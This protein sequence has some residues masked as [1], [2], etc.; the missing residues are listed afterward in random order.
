MT[1]IL[2][3]VTFDLAA[4]ALDLS[5][6]RHQVIAA[7]IANRA[8]AGYEPR[9]LDFEAQLAAITRE[10]D[11]GAAPESLA[12]DLRTLASR[13]PPTIESGATV[14]LDD[15]INR[16]VA[17]TVQYQAVLAGLGKL[18]S[19]NRIAIEGGSA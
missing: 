19:L 16:L 3:N 17:N 12:Q 2:N 18:G 1:G 13:V 9:R 15:E 14:Q 8:T 6:A 10:I 4:A 5:M 7:N 11:A